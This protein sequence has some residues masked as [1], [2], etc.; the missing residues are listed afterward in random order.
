MTKD[1][2]KNMYLMGSREIW[3][4]RQCSANP[5]T[6]CQQP[7]GQCGKV[8]KPQYNQMGGVLRQEMQQKYQAQH[9][10]TMNPL[11]ERQMLAVSAVSNVLT[12]WMGTNDIMGPNISTEMRNELMRLELNQVAD[13]N[14]IMQLEQNI[15][16]ILNIIR[17][18][19]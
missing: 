9:D 10:V 17:R 7:P 4:C 1:E 8:L 15:I 3:D 16:N 13:R 12:Q 11:N 6:F 18:I 14:S 19:P 2:F 5:L